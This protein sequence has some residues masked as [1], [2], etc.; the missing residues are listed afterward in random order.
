[1]TPIIF[2][3]T[4]ADAIEA[5]RL[6]FTQGY[7][8]KFFRNILIIAFVAAA[9]ACISF[10]F[11]TITFKKYLTLFGYVFAFYIIL[12]LL[13]LPICN[14]IIIPYRV[15]K[16]FKQMPALS[17]EMQLSWTQDDFIFR[18]GKSVSEVPF[19]DLHK[20]CANDNSLTIFP[21]DLIHYMIPRRAFPD[22][23][24][25]TEIQ[26]RLHENGVKKI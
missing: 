13:F 5:T 18:S 14:H 20:W 15:R 1:M 12:W 6:G 3:L 21:S 23:A 24:V 2:T 11:D 7:K 10:F 25:F 17:Q 8:N 22:D 26:N 19:S 4:E 9:V 16:Q